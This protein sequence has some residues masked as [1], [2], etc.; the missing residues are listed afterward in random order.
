MKKCEKNVNKASYP[1]V[2]L[3]VPVYNVEEY[4]EDCLESIV[5]QTYKNFELILVN[6]GSTDKSGRICDKFKSDNEL[7]N[8]IVIHKENGGLSSARNAGIDVASGEYISFVDSDDVISAEYLMQMVKIAY[9]KDVDVVQCENSKIRNEMDSGE[10]G[11]EIL[12]SE[13]SLEHFLLRDK[14]YVASWAK[15]YKRYLFDQGI[16]FPFGKM[17]EDNFTT[18]KLVYNAHNTACLD[19]VL[20]WHRPRQGSI[21][22]SQF[23]ERNL[24]ILEVKDEIKCFLGDESK[25]YADKIEYYSFRTNLYVYNRLV[26]SEQRKQ[27]EE[28]ERKLKES[29]V[30]TK[31]KYLTFKNIVSQKLLKRLPNI[32]VLIIKRKLKKEG[33]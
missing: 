15:L 30:D 23:S 12:N 26:V 8:I 20:Y 29:I 9:E 4:L 21:M 17:N 28:V 32:Y 19:M 10:K 1:F 31:L 6:D 5:Q 11:V 18:Y 27:Y 13:E 22:H 2:S 14:I 25:K 16:R 7:L 24:H 3:I 33:L